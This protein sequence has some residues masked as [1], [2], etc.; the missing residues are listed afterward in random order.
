MIQP[1]GPDAA[2]QP[3][4]TFSLENCDE[5]ITPDCLRALY[6]FVNGTLGV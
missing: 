4:V 6:N 1:A 5:Y 2:P 3:E